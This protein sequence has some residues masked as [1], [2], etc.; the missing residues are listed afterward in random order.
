MDKFDVLSQD[1]QPFQECKIRTIVIFNLY[2]N[3]C[4]YF[5]VLK[6]LHAELICYE[7]KNKR[8]YLLLRNMFFNII[9]NMYN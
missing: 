2:Y 1:L 3:N 7:E 8:C 5:V 4:F 9:K 6:M